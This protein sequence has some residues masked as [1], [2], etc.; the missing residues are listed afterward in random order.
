MVYE[1][2]VW[3]EKYRPKTFEEVVGQE[4][5]VKRVKNLVNSLNIPHLLFAGPA[6]TGKSTLAL[7]IVRELFGKN[8]ENNYLEL[9]ASDERGIDVVRQ[10]VKD[11]ARTKALASVPFKVIFLDEADALTREAQQALRRTMENFTST[12][13]F[14]LSCVTPDT[15][16][17]LPEE[18]EI[19]IEDF[20]KNF[21]N[22]TVTMIQNF[23]ND[24]IKEDL[25]LASI[26]MDPKIIGKKTL[27]IKTMTGRKLR[28]TEDHNLL[29]N[30]GWKPAGKITKEDKLLTYPNLETTY[31]EDNKNKV[32]D[33]APFIEFITKSEEKE[34]F[35]SLGATDMYAKLK[36][37][38][39][40]SIIKK[41]KVLDCLIKAGKGLTKKEKDIYNIINNKKN[42]SRLEIQ[43][44]INLSRIRTDQILRSI[45][46]KGH[47]LRYNTNKTHYF[48]ANNT[49]PPI[50]RNLM[51]IKKIIEK[52]YQIKISYTS[53]RKALDK[54][55]MH[56]KLDR[57]LG[58]LKRKDLL[59]LTYSNKQ[60]GAL[61][62]IVAFMFGD[63]HLTTN[64]KRLIFTGN[65]AALK[66]VKK[67]LEILGYSG[68]N[69]VTKE[70]SHE[71]NGRKIKGKTTFFNVNSKAA[72]IFLQFLGVPK[73]DKASTIYK[74]PPF[75]KYGTK[76]VKREFLRGLF[77]CEADKPSCK[78]YNFNAVSIRQNK[79]KSLTANMLEFYNELKKLLSDFEV[80]SYI[81]ILDKNE[82]RK[83]DSQEVFTFSL[84]IK[85]TNENLYKFFSRVGY[86]YEDYKSRLSRLASEYLRHKLF[87]INLW[88]EK[89]Q[90][91][92]I[93]VTKG[94]SY[95]ETAK[96]LG[97]T[98]D[99]VAAQLKSKK[100]RLPRKNFIKFNEWVKKYENNCF[101]ENEIIDINEIFCN[102]VRDITCLQDH[103]FISNGFVSHN[104]NYSS[105]IIDPIQ[106]RCAIFRFKLLEK[107]EID[108]IVNRI[109]SSEKLDIPQEAYDVIYEASEGDCRRV[110]NLLQS[111]ASISPR[112]TKELIDT[113]MSSA[114]PADIKV[115]LEYAISGDFIKARDKLLDLMLREGLSG[116]DIIKSIQKEI[117]NLQIDPQ[118]KVELTSK[119]G[120]IEFRMVE[121]SDEFIQLESLL[122]SFVLANREK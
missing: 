62:R 10:K 57:I 4:E 24:V 92:L 71:L 86:A 104:C 38:D 16:I 79:I 65:E 69:I 103:N 34:G 107:K 91:I 29:T 66:K 82:K 31:F 59:D 20:M 116:Q 109:S 26:Q 17:L 46:N 115:V 97:C 119:T 117:W 83:K 48:V 105:K 63:G 89:S 118:L 15:R 96:L 9:N 19:T 40:E 45:E 122:A 88:K 7:I 93:E 5:I 100:I 76:F 75:I 39:K 68:Q 84:L 56:G 58:E 78:R 43:R 18:V 102:D 22:K 23:N 67:D 53:I 73:G 87:T 113:V 13:R 72:S 27:E 112:I 12:C 64:D 106:S 77:G 121:G 99:F 32:I 52:E 111:T 60:I 74:I 50:L 101:I 8:W 11:F 2:N 110:I 28:V 6:G 1:N 51:D 95:R 36:T 30:N 14:I 120:E 81:N 3:T 25:I 94:R 54:S 49:E 33:L 70:I 61:S 41:I 85:P 35:K 90:S 37:H 80:D 47:I 42:I 114:K 21:E 55:I 44:L 98:P 108:K